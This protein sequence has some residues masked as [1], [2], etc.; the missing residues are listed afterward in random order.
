MLFTLFPEMWVKSP[1]PV[2]TSPLPE[3][4]KDA[5]IF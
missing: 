5:M 3:L 1:H 2:A 4:V